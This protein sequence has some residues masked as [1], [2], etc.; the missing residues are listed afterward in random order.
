V[1][2]YAQ[3]VSRASELLSVFEDRARVSG[4]I[5]LLDARTASELVTAAEAAGVRVLG[6]DAF[7]VSDGGIQPLQEYELD[8]E[9]AATPYQTTRAFLEQFVGRDLMFEV[10]LSDGE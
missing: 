2:G 7:R 9:A 10:A 4:R 8:V 1:R 5:R 3:D 6:V